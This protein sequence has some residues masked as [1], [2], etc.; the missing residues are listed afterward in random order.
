MS[1]LLRPDVRRMSQ[2]SCAGR[3]CVL[4]CPPE[5]SER[6]VRRGDGLLAV[7]E[8]LRTCERVGKEVQLMTYA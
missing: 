7:A 4:E 5:V 3:G 2:Q 1:A 8:N 6:P